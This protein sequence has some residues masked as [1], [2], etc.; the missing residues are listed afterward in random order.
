MNSIQ[1]VKN[2]EEAFE[3]SMVLSVLAT[4]RMVSRALAT[5][6][7]YTVIVG[8][9]WGSTTRKMGR[10]GEEAQI[11]KVMAVRRRLT[12]DYNLN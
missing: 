9:K 5:T 8:L 10:K 7:P 4:G 2:T 11:I 1:V 12:I 6:S 3:F